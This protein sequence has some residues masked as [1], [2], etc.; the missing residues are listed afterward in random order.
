MA[1]YGQFCPVAQAAEL[2]AE[3]WTL[4]VVREMVSG[5]HRFNEIHNGVPA[6]SPT[7]LTKRLRA[8][9][10]A[11]VVEHRD[12]GYHLTRAGRELEPLIAGLGL[13]G[14][15]WVRRTVSREDADAALLMW[16]VRRSVRLEAAPRGRT[17]V[18]FRFRFRT[19]PAPKRWWW[20]VLDGAAPE[21]CIKDPGFGVDLTV[22]SEPRVLA[23]V[24]LGDMT[25]AAAL[26]RGSVRLEG[27]EYLVRAFPAWFGLSPL[28]GIERPR[29]ARAA[30][31]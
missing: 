25:L 5:S 7:L 27:P 11:G 19:P 31:R 12:G 9:E 3:R 14:E 28:A 17:V 1:G 4:L 15:R 13:W 21:L 24:Y 29:R 6:M 16:T 10:Q 30:A 18:H 20:L 2:L 8:L 22:R 26:R 23:S